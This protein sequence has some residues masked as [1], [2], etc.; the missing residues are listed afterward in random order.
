MGRWLQIAISGVAAAGAFLAMEP[1]HWDS[2]RSEAMLVLSVLAA[3]VLFRLGRGVPLVSIDHL[4]VDEAESLAEAYR[5]VSR[6][7]AFVAGVTAAALIGLAMIGI[8]HHLIELHLPPDIRSVCAKLA[9]AVL[10]AIIAFAF[11]RAFM[12]VRGDLSSVAVQSESIVKSVRRRHARDVEAAL[13]KAEKTQPFNKPSN[14]G[15]IIK[16]P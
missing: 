14:Y 7:L 1:C 12:L 8:V 11:C 5:I 6:R 9:T 3:A 10:A 13:D 15:D 4:E 16:H 2:I